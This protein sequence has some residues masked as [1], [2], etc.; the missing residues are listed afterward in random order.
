MYEPA[1]ATQSDARS[2]LPASAHCR[3]LAAAA[4]ADSASRVLCC[5]VA[6]V[7][8]A[9]NNDNIYLTV[10]VSDAKEIKVEMTE[11]GV[12]FAAQSQGKEYALD[13]KLKKK[14][15]AKKSTYAV[16]GRELQFLLVKAEDD[17]GWSDNMHTHTAADEGQGTVSSIARDLLIVPV[18]CC[19]RWNALLADK[20]AYKGRCKIDW[21]LWSAEGTRIGLCL[22]SLS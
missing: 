13:L 22:V 8:G 2:P 12:T 7:A 17:Q 15:D 20:N 9:E 14:I 16:K 1:T 18:V 4:A 19:V 6:S 5:C 11:T 21:D 10:E 3:L